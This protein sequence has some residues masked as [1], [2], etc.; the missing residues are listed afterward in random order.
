MGEL[1]DEIEDDSLDEALL[2]LP[3]PPVDH[4]AVLDRR[5][6]PELQSDRNDVVPRP[7]SFPKPSQ[8]FIKP[9]PPRTRSNGAVSSKPWTDEYAPVDL[10]ELVVHK[11]K[12]MD[13]QTWL[14][15]Y[16]A[17]RERSVCTLSG[18]CRS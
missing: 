18:P 10:T 11:K 5:K 9:P 3:D 1:H 6:K 13:V 14:G 7:E 15:D 16:F 4:K 2:K 8:K 12:V 17:G